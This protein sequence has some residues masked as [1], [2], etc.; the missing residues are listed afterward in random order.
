M[1]DQDEG[2]TRSPRSLGRDRRRKGASRSIDGSSIR[3]ALAAI[4]R[5]ISSRYTLFK[6]VRKETA[7]EAW[8]ALRTMRLGTEPV[9]RARAPGRRP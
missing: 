3:L 2:V 8:Q 6:I 4:H 1:G 5:G 7:R 9:M